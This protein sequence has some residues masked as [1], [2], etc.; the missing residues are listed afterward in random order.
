MCWSSSWVR[1]IC[2]VARVSCSTGRTMRRAMSQAAAA[3]TAV[4]INAM[5]RRRR[6][7]V[8]MTLFVVA[9]LRAICAAPPLRSGVVST[10][11]SVPLIVTVR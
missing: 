10:R 3:A 2:S 11:Y 6:S 1:A 4:P 5:R 8:E 7:S 9:M